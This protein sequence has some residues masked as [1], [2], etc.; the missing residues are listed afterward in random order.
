MP[1]AKINYS[2]VETTF[3]DENGNTRKTVQ[4]S[5]HK[6]E[7]TGE[8]DYIKIYTKMWC[9][10]NQIPN[11]WRD[12]F[13]ELVTRMSYANIDTTK[14]QIVATGGPTREAICRALGWKAN[15]YQK[16]L[17]A[18]CD[19]GAIRKCNRGFYQISPMYA[20]RGEWKYNPKLQRGGV[21]NLKAT[22]DFKS[23]QSSVNV[24]WGDDEKDTPL[25]RMYRDGLGV[26]P[27]DATVL[28]EIK[29]QPQPSAK[30]TPEPIT[31]EELLALEDD[32]V[33][34]NLNNAGVIVHG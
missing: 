3:T 6:I 18:L 7:P 12:L 27:T 15:M 23:G 13:F 5:T 29:I 30:P 28:K 33:P 4:E 9:E 26:K 16:G 17:R 31:S 34:A 24:I 8:P 21:E 22:F 1:S 14:S 10:F 32:P 20:G 2:K 25:N 19:V 11:K